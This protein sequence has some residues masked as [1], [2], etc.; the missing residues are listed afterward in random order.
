MTKSMTIKGVSSMA[1]RQLLAELVADY[2]KQTA[3]DIQ[4]ESVGG[5]NASNR[6]LAGEYFDVVFLAS[7]AIQATLTRRAR[8][9]WSILAWRLPL[10]RV[11]Q[12]PISP[13]KPH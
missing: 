12:R 3:I 11:Q 7:E 10:R 1:T 4:I 5:V 6:V 9:I 13:L 2:T 8:S